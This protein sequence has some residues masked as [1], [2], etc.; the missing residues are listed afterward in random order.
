VT[1]AL[2]DAIHDAG[3]DHAAVAVPG[4]HDI[5]EILEQDH[6]HHV[7]DVGLEVDL[8]AVEM[9]P[10]AE[11]GE[12]DAVHGV[13]ARAKTDRSWQ[14]AVARGWTIRT[15]P[16]GHVAQQEDPRGVATLMQEAVRDVNR[17][18]GAAGQNQAR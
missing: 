6:V 4:E 17:P 15:F 1:N 12:R 7:L 14:R 8:G 10:L 3:D 5:V 9:H 11:A 2:G 16:G 13:T 18:V